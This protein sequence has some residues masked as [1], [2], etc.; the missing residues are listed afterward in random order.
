[1]FKKMKSIFLGKA[2]KSNE[3][4]SEKFSVLW[5]LP[6]LSSDAIS[7]VAYAG[8]EILMVLVPVLGIAAF[9]PLLGAS[10][11]IVALLLILVFSYR[12]TID[13]YPSGGGSYIVA[14]DNLGQIPGLIAAAAL[15]IDYILTV[16][17]STS[18]GTAAIT[19]AFPEL[20]PY[21]V[22]ITLFFILLLT[23]GNLRGMR[24]SSRLFG[25]PTYLFILCILIMIFAGIFKVV[26][27]GQV[28]P[29]PTTLKQ[30]IEDLSLFLFL[31][32]F[33]SGCTALTGVEAVSN[34][35]PNFQKPRQKNAKKVLALLALVVF[36][37]FGGVSFLASIYKVV[38]QENV[39][40]VAQIATQIFGGNSFM[41]YAV[42]ATTAI[43][44]IMAA[45]TSY[46]D[47]PLLLSILGKDGFVPRQL[48]TRG[49]RL[50]FS[51]GIIL[52][53]LLSSS[54]VVVFQATTHHLL[55]LYAV[56]VFLSF[57]L[58]QYGMFHK[59]MKSKEGHWKHKA[60]INGIGAI[61]TGITCIIIAAT[62]FMLG[63]WVVLI[64]IPLLVLF[65]SRVRKHYT[66]VRNNLTIEQS[67]SDLIIKEEVHNRI[68]LPIQSVN[69]SFIKA[70][71]F[72]LAT[73]Q[74][75]ELYHVSTKPKVTERLIEQYHQLGIEVPLIIE[76]APYR[77][78][79]EMLL[80]HIDKI[81]ATLGK[82]EMLT[83]V[84]PQF[85]IPNWWHRALHNQTSVFLRAALL[86]RRNV[87]VVSIPYI[88]N[89]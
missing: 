48:S 55:P 39:T 40:V 12:Q 72:A 46:A 64:C 56:G 38:P 26:I 9:K 57:T 1:M 81:E 82:H 29:Q 78:V 16:A 36:V 32:A 62:K 43:I 61:V 75:L 63:A 54:L 73:G 37:I 67:A 87:A 58:S 59:W 66:K 50:S 84:L 21:K 22:A 25:V 4:D 35:I 47:L 86:N 76:D 24:D 20:L 6:V 60:V 85:I 49:T 23:L 80:A 5:G 3:L 70:L 34:G 28:P 42:Q 74:P 89:E 88:I 15:T 53:C 7:S 41:F 11:A 2:L 33:A 44:L 17:V 68:I 51:Y 69:K 77:N 83:V 52:L 19:S 71:N 10:L 31:R 27:L 13:S 45:N 65:M 14:S 8:E 18:S 30:P 79:N